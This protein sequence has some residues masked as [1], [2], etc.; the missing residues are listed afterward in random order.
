MS[1][2][3]LFIGILVV[4][5]AGI[6]SLNKLTYTFETDPL[7]FGTSEQIKQYTEY[8][9]A[10]EED[11]ETIAIGLEKEDGFTNIQDYRTVNELTESIKQIQG[12]SE[13][14]SIENFGLPAFNG[15]ITVYE[16][17]LPIEDA[18]SFQAKFDQL[19]KFSDIT[20]KFLS[21]DRTALCFYI[22]IDEEFE[23]S[24]VIQELYQRLDTS[25]FSNSYYVAGTPAAK[26]E[27]ERLLA[28]ETL[29]ISVIGCLLILFC[30]LWLLPNFHRI[31]LTL[32]FT[33]FNVSTT[34]LFMYVCKIEV[35]SLSSAVPSIIAI[36]S[37]TDI[38]H[39]QYHYNK[40]KEENLADAVIKKQLFKKIGL[41]LILTSASNLAGFVVFFFNGGIEMITGLALAASFG[42]VFAYFSSRVLLPFFLTYDESNAMRRRQSQIEKLVS[43]KVDFTQRNYKKIILVSLVIIPLMVAGAIHYQTIDMRY[44]NQADLDLGLSRSSA[45]YDTKFQGIRDIEVVLDSEEDLLRPEV[46]QRID[47]IEKYLLNEYGCRTTFS[48]NTA[49]KRHQ[50]Y[51]TGGDPDAFRLPSKMTA[52]YKEALYENQS[53]LGLNSVL[54]KDGKTAR[55]IGS[56]PD[57]GTHQARQRNKALEEFLLSFND[58]NTTAYISGKAYIFDYNVFHLSKFVLWALGIGLLLVAIVVALL[59]RS[60][61]I[62]LVTL[63]A[64]ALPL[65]F[66][67]LVMLFFGIQLNPG[68]I[69]I[70]TI[71]LGIA[72]DDSIYILGHYY[73]SAKQSGRKTEILVKSLKSNSLPLLATSVVLSISFLALTIS[74][75]HFTMSFGIII[76]SSLIFAYMTD[77]LFIPSMIFWA[78]KRSRK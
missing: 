14:N 32:L 75:Y 76:S 8:R 77:M 4:I 59:F 71:I 69:F 49:V 68:S 21:D 23:D 73:S 31:A 66:G 7:A 63:L 65:F 38:T 48:L 60:V 53:E 24:Q 12:V 70:L 64:N 2:K 51:S 18:S 58:E 5:G 61:F 27:G 33:V 54:S 16:P 13:V 52:N 45:F 17:F 67:V 56:L 1:R 22:F 62:G 28:R 10:F 37:F 42:I 43:Q 25:E 34:L 50:R 55:I 20:E 41:P 78:L 44:Y 36:L 15:L 40:L 3:L 46:L 35:T 29:W 9:Q 72:L 39:I 74:N 57:I 30:M 11:R 47:S 6:W 19:N 26:E